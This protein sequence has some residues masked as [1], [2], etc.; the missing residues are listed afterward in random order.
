MKKRIILVLGLFSVLLVGC[1]SK[2]QL[3]RVKQSESEAELLGRVGTSIVEYDLKFADVMNK[4]DSLNLS[5]ELYENGEHVDTTIINS[6]SGFLDDKDI[7][8]SW[9]RTKIGNDSEKFILASGGAVGNVF[10]D[11][12]KDFAATSFDSFESIKEIEKDTDYYLAYYLI[13]DGQFY[14]FQ[15]NYDPSAF[16]ETLSKHDKAYVLQLRIDENNLTAQEGK[17]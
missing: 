1:G 2:S 7:K 17:K 14:T 5:V 12:P 6:T 16:L 10:I 11:L 8:L 4:E 9:G 15:K 3:T 13:T